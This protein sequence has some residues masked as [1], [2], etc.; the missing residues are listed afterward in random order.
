MK[1][2]VPYPP[3]GQGDILGRILAKKMSELLGQQVLIDNRGGAGG[4]LGVDAGAKS[5]PDGYT[6]IMGG[7]STLTLA[8]ALNPA[9]PYDPL[10]D[11][12]PVSNVAIVT[13]GLAVNPNLPARTVKELI[14]LAR[15]KKGSLT[16]GA[17]HG[18]VSNVAMEVFKSMAGVDIL[19]VPYKGFAPALTDLLSGQIDMT[20][21]D[22]SAMVPYAKAGKLRILA[23]TSARRSAASAQ[24]PTIAEAGVAGYAVDFWFGFVVPAATP[25]QIVARLNSATVNSLNAPEVHQVFDERG[26]VATGGTPEEFGATIKAEIEKSVRIVRSANIRLQ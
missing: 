20:V 12:K 11:L 14:E 3:G 4:V 8:P 15:S 6:L 9:L 2:I 19:H 25:A 13:A 21:G 16:Y 24:Y 10:R 1:M 5:A 18:S 7:S 22:Y 26:Y 17:G 23:T